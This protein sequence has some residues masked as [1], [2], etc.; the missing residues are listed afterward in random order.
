[1]RHDDI[2][3]RAYEIW[4]RDGC[5]HGKDC[6]HW[7]QA[8]QE[9]RNETNHFPKDRKQDSVSF[10]QTEAKLSRKNS[11]PGREPQNRDARKADTMAV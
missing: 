9:L 4:Q 6:E 2:S 5:C 7:A 3:R 11:R 10:Q 8:E 1:M